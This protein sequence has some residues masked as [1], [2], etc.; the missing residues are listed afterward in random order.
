[1]LHDELADQGIHVAHTAIAGNIAP[2]GDNEPEAIADLLW[3][4]HADPGPFQTRV[5]I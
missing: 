2:G 3:S 5:G 1:M 4:L